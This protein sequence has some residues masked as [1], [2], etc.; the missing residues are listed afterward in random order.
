MNSGASEKM[1]IRIQ[2]L[3]EKVILKDDRIRKL[4]SIESSGD[5][6]DSS[7]RNIDKVRSIRPISIIVL[8][9]RRICDLS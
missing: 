2:C 6:I 4:V 7:N 3:S 9:T 1:I 5:L 8:F